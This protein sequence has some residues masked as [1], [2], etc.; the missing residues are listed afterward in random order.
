MPD[1]VNEIAASDI[2]KID[3][4]ELYITIDLQNGI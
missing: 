1:A 2:L 3:I 4:Q